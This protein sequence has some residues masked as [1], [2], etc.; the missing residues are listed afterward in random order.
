[1]HM[2]NAAIVKGKNHS[3]AAA[4]CINKY[5]KRERKDGVGV[6]H[7]GV[8]RW[9]VSLECLVGVIVKIHASI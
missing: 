6:C 9:S 2:V 5:T 1:M 7:V 3:F 8:S 4:P